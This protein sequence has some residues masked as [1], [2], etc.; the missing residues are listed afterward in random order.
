MQGLLR[1]TVLL[2]RLIHPDIR[3]SDFKRANF[4]KEL[5]G[6]HSLKAW[7]YRLGEHKG[8]F[9]ETNDWSKWTEEMEDYCVQDTRVTYRL[10]EDLMREQP[11]HISMKRLI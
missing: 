9:G 11:S 7:G 4:P 5:I 2:S 8:D 3:D 1:D 6:S 10:Y